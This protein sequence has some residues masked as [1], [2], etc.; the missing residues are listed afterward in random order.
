MQKTLFPQDNTVHLNQ[1]AIRITPLWALPLLSIAFLVIGQISAL[2]PLKY[3]GIISKENVDNY[4]HILYFII[5]SFAMVSVLIVLWVRYYEKQTLA[6]VGLRFNAKTLS[7]Y[8]SGLLLGLLFGTVIVYS[9]IFLGGYA[10][11]QE[12]DVTLSDWTPVLVLLLAF[13]VQAG[14]EELLFRGWLMNHLHSQYGVWVAVIGNSL[15]FTLF[16]IG[17]IDFETATW[18]SAAIFLVM[19]LLLSIFLSFH[20]IKTASIWGA[21]AFHASWNW[22]FIN[23]FGLP[24]TGIDLDIKPIWR[25]YAPVA[26][27]PVWLSGGVMGPEDTVVSLAVLLLACFWYMRKSMNKNQPE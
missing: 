1:K 12:I 3:L 4:P 10:L 21:C 2:L 13:M 14:T 7:Q 27:A 25:D 15:L 24:T 22:I 6:S 17:S 11:E 23:V 26:E 8:L 20:A 5:G 19:C 16:H 18:T 9:I